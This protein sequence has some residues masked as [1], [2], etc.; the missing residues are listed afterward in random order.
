MLEQI[1]QYN[2]Y[3]AVCKEAQRVDKDKKGK[4]KKNPEVKPVKYSY[5]QLKSKGIIVSVDVSN[6]VRGWVVTKE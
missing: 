3:L 4:K 2:D 5:K 6:A 1:R